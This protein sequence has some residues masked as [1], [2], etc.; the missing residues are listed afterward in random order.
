MERR[1]NV[2]MPLKSA[3][4]TAAIIVSLAVALFG[5]GIVSDGYDQTVQTNVSLATIKTTLEHQVEMQR[6][7]LET[8]NQVKEDVNEHGMTLY[9]H[10][11]RIK[12]LESVHTTKKEN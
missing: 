10:D 5:N 12:S 1:E 9:T 7:S 4:P 6:L 3:L 2:Q 11:L 8:I